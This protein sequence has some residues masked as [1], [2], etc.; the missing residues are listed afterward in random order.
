MAGALGIRLS[1]P[2]IYGDRVADEPWLNADAPDP[3]AEALSRGLALYV[4]AMVLCS[5]A[6]VALA[7]ALGTAF[8]TPALVAAPAFGATSL[9][10][11]LAAAVVALRRQ[12]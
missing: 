3:G 1:G 12:G 9:V 11:G 2:R 8:A 10:S 4:R 6:L 7:L 5:A